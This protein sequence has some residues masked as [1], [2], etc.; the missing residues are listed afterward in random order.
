MLLFYLDEVGNSSLSPSSLVAHPYFIMGAMCIGDS[1]RL[2]LFSQLSRLKDDVF[3][4]WKRSAWKE[5]E[6]KGSYLAQA[7]LR[8][9]H[10]RS[11]LR[12]SFYKSLTGS[13][14]ER[15]IT[16]LFNI[17]HGF[18]PRFYV[19]GIDKHDLLR[20]SSGSVQPPVG[21]AYAYLQVRAALLVSEVYGRTE[22]AIFI[23]DEER[24]HE[25]LFVEGEISRVRDQVLTT[26]HKRPD[27]GVILEKPIWVNRG[28]LEVDR[29]ICQL[30]D[31]AVYIVGTAMKKGL[32]NGDWLQRLSPYLARHWTSGQVWDAGITIVP[33]PKR[34]PKFGT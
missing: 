5:S 14:I 21:L 20:K 18:N 2:S 12:P 7:V 31:F 17:I 27:I 26:V 3:P 28:E 6:I 29:E 34:Y 25:R 13:A 10:G 19:V 22:G 11:P 30:I 9:E 15:L 24:N 8:Q 16:R 32:W 1:Q 23:A 4:G 33:K